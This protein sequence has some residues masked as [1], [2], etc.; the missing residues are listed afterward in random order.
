MIIS[1]QNVREF[2]TTDL[3]D[4]QLEMKLTAIEHFI[5]RYTNNGFQL[6]EVRSESVISADR[7]LTPPSL[8]EVGDTI[9]ITQS[10]YNKGIYTVT[11]IDGR[12]MAVAQRLYS[13]ID[14][15]VTKVYYPPDVVSGAV[16]MLEWEIENTGRIGIQS[17]KLSRHSVTYFNTEEN[18]TAGYP[19]TV[20]GFLKPYM[21]ARF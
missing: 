12:G 17:E 7:I 16:K 8:V 9:E 14:N 4:R 20:M 11:E 10:L 18:S 2:I 3:T 6:R 21:K 15:L 13:C 5:R 19:K 1:V